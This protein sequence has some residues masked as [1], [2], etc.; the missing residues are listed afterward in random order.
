MQDKSPEW[1]KQWSMF[2]APDRFLLEEWIAPVVL[3]DFRDK[4]VLE[5]GC[6]AGQHT[7][8]IAPFA[9]SITAIDLN[10]ADIARH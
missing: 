9:T 10:T 3:D 8:F 6:G 7:N 2:K 1:F 4:D 5:C